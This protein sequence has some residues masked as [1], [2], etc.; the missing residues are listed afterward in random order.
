MFKRRVGCHQI[1]HAVA[2]A[3]VVLPPRHFVCVGVQVWA[4]DVVV[5]VPIPNNLTAMRVALE[6][7]GISFVGASGITF[8]KPAKRAKT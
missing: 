2:D 5:R 7:V 1:E 6:S 4:S 3:S 8:A